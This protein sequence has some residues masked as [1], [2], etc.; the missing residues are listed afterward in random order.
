MSNIA[1][2]LLDG[3]AAMAP[4]NTATN[5]DGTTMFQWSTLPNTAALLNISCGAAFS[6][7]VYDADIVLVG[8]SAQIPD[9][10]SLGVTIPPG[11]MCHWSASVFTGATKADDLAGPGGWVRYPFFAKANGDGSVSSTKSRDFTP[12]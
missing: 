8:T 2:K 6:Q 1:L 9:T 3:I 10:G 7:P 12:K 5:V 4:M 11:G